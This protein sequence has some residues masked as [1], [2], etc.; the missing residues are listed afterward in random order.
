MAYGQGLYSTWFYGVDGNYI[1]A[2]ASI[3]ASSTTTAVGQVTIKGAAA[4][5]AASTTTVAFERVAERSVPI[6]VLA[7]MVPI[8]AINA[9]GF[10]GSHSIAYGYRWR[11]PRCTI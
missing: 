3:S 6:S 11:D 9:G 10:C 7:E 1:D 2:S 8:G 4:L 5:T